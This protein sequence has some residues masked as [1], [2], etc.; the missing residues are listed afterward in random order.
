MESGFIHQQRCELYIDSWRDGTLTQTSFQS[1]TGTTTSPD[2]RHGVD[3][4]L[5][6]VPM[7][8]GG[9]VLCVVGGS[10][11]HIVTIMILLLLSGMAWVGCLVL[12][13]VAP[14]PLQ[15]WA[16]VFTSTICATLGIDLT[17]TISIVFLSAVQPLKY[18][19]LAGAMSSILVNLGMSFSLSISEIVSS[20]AKDSLG[21]DASAD[22]R[23]NW[24]FQAALLYG[25]ASA[26]LGLLICILFVRISSDVARAPSSEANDEEAQR[27]DMHGSTCALRRSPSSEAPTFGATSGRNTRSVTPSQQSIV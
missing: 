4:A 20:K 14:F 9:L 13:G 22:E 17:Y 11:M 5:W 6:Y 15:Y 18:Q 7:A 1:P 24:G 16:F 10:V 12:L 25:A 23:T 19:G 26:G 3:L 8:V 2:G 27:V 21:S